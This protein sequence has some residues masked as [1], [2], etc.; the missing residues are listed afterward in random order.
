MRDRSTEV[1]GG[2]SVVVSIVNAALIA[3]LTIVEKASHFS[4]GP[5]PWNGYVVGAEYLR[6]RVCLHTAV[7]ES[8]VRL[9]RVPALLLAYALHH[10][11]SLLTRRTVH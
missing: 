7:S 6:I 4:S 2:Y 11:F 9:E 5:E 10:A 1:A 8:Q 3:L